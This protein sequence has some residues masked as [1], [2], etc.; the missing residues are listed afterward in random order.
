MIKTIVLKYQVLQGRS[1]PY[2]G[3]FDRTAGHPA[4]QNRS[5]G[6]NRLLVPPFHFSTFG[7]RFSVASLLIGNNLSDEVKSTQLLST[8][9]QRRKK[10]LFQ[11]SCPGLIA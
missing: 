2:L 10:I 4:S 9:R 1:Q 11:M 3:M 7:H 6:T 5:V 8:F